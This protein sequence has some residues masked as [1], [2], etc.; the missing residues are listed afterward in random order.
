MGRLFGTDGVRGVANSEL[1]CER[2]MSIG[3][4]AAAVLS[5]GC[6]R[7]PVFVIGADTRASSD[8]LM[9]AVSAGLCSYG[10]DVIQLGVVPTPAVAYLVEKYKA[11]AGVMISASHNPADFNGIKIFSGD[12]FKLPDLLE[13]RIEAIV[14]DGAAV[15]ALPTGGGVGRVTRAENACRDYISHV[16]ST[17]P[18]SLD[19]LRIAV[20][21][22]NGS[23]SAT[24]QALFSELGAQVQL[25][26]AS[27]D[28]VNINDGCGSTHLEALSAYVTEHQLDCGVAFDGDADRCL[29][30]D[31]HGDVVDGDMIMSICALDLKERGRLNRNAVV[32]TI[33]TNFGFGKFCEENGIRFEATKVGDRFVL[34]EMLLEDYSFGGEQSGHVIFRDFATTGDGQLTAAQLLSI[35]RRKGKTLSELNCVMTKYPQTMVNLHVTA[36]GKL[37]FYTDPEVKAA[38]EAAKTLLGNGGRVVVRPSGT[39]PLIRVMAEGEDAALIARA[40]QDIA[41]VIGTRLA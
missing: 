36:E 13:E 21:C 34:E 27:P 1:S 32:G 8:M 9:C 29:C 33:M 41:E 26:F 3:R 39:E 19:G 16:K 17:V 31:E 15:P 28:G 10:A 7:R 18:Y 6:R 12:G 2:A 35:M 20:D 24:A 40:A 14:L 22:A 25:L 4:A 38:I 23:A 37:R 11:D 5:E 30:V